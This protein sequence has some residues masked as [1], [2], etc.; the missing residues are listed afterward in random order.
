MSRAFVKEDDDLQRFREEAMEETQ[1]R[2]WL[3]IQEK[4][5]SF[6]KESPKALEIDS[7]KRKEW[8]FSIEKDVRRCYELLGISEEDRRE[9]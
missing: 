9:I 5:L 6:L 3:A 7:E 1:L 2:E 8:I 4:K